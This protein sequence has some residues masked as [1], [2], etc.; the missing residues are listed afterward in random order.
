MSDKRVL[1]NIRNVGGRGGSFNLIGRDAIL[2]CTVV[3]PS[4]QPRESCVRCVSL[5]TRTRKRREPTTADN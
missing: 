1:R 3:T 2:N 5:V 4:S